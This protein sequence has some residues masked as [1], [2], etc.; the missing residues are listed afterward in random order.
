M[1]WQQK[2][3]RR[4]YLDYFVNHPLNHREVSTSPLIPSD[5]PTLL[6]TNAGMN[7][8][9]ALL[10][11]QEKRDYTRACSVQKCIRAGGKH[12]DLDAVGKDG[13]HL[14][15]FEMLGNWSF[16]NY[17]KLDTIKMAWDLSVNV[18][19]LDPSRIYVTVY[20]DDDESYDIWKDVI[21]V[22]PSHIYRMGNLEEGD[23]EN[24]W[25]MGP[26]GPCGPCTE[27]FFDLGPE[28]G[29]GPEDVMGGEGDRFMEYW[30][31]VF[32]QYDRQEDGT[33]VPLPALSVDTGMGMERITM[34]LQGKVS[35]YETDIF[36]GM[37]Q[38]IAQMAGADWHHPQQRIDL[39]VIADHIRS[40]TFVISEG[41]MFS[42]EG[43]GY[44]LRRILRRAVR[45]G[46]K[47]GFNEPFL[48][49][50]VPFVAE[51]FEG[52]YEL[53][54]HILA[55]TAESLK[56]EEA[57]FFRTIDKGM[58]RIHSI[59]EER[60]LQNQ[61]LVISGREAFELYDTFGFPVDL[62]RIEANEQGFEVD[63]NEFTK[64]M[65]VQKNRSRQAARFYEDDG[66]T[67][68]ILQDGGGRGFA[69]YGLQSL[70]TT[71]MRYRTLDQ[72]AELILDHTPFYAESGGEVS[73]HGVIK[74]PGFE[75]QIEQVQKINGIIHH[76]GILKGT[77]SLSA[78][79]TLV[80]EVD[81]Q[82]RQE[83]TIHHT[84]THLLHAAL[85]ELLGSH[86]EQ[87]GSVVEPNRLR[88]DFSHP[89]AL[90]E[91][92]IKA[93]E[94]WVNTRIRRNETV[95]IT[96]NVP[97][98]TAKAQG[99]VALFGEKYGEFVR[100]VKAGHDSFELCGGNH[101]Q[102]TGDIGHFMITSESAVAA[103]IRRLEAVVGHAAEQWIN[104]DRE[105]LKE[106]S[107]HLKIDKFKIGERI[108][109]LQEEIK[110]L[111]KSVEKARKGGGGIDVDAILSTAID[112]GDHSFVVAKVEVENQEA[113][114][115]LV[116]LLRQKAP[117][118]AFLCVATENDKVLLS[119]GIGHDLKQDKKYHAG[120]LISATAPIVGG[121]GGGRNDFAN[122]GGSAIDQIDQLIAQAPAL[123]AQII[124]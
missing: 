122:G 51:T 13:R 14:T 37:I 79:D 33:L 67:W 57:R 98:S 121:K 32:M 23:E 3:I 21:G 4:A 74:G 114:T 73:D 62:T 83:K 58:H 81:L 52:V 119:A 78:E 36:Q 60:R 19:R 92:E 16:G 118:F 69:G 2:Q 5:D 86:V 112:M 8:F 54:T 87:K 107:R 89:K 7:Q 59:M 97:I 46:R 45:H 31:N 29:T 50:L 68:V 49:K 66:G 91:T 47:L 88:F 41:G 6:F 56:D 117:K 28:A 22:D 120:K 63:E 94:Q 42:N 27:L 70:E 75:I 72:R 124:K 71:V 53:P 102:A 55:Q 84:A 96:E 106:L 34:I 25:S 113:L 104:Q 20:K 30:N 101:V 109:A 18:Y 44:V 115:A 35:V 95:N 9:K 61:P 105:I 76:I 26:T 90:S 24:F 39:Q 82:R 38:K 93:I 65:E 12:N 64:E 85:K 77:I 11:G 1:S 99:V 48:W 111:K 15:F 108:V 123:W 17:G 103:G 40:L 116:D 43:R 10:L 110:T 100:T 80:A